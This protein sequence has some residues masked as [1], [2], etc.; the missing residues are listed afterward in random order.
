MLGS[1]G[2]PVSGTIGRVSTKGLPCVRRP[3]RSRSPEGAVGS[4]SNGEPGL[5]SVIGPLELERGEADE[6]VAREDGRGMAGRG[7]Q[8]VHVGRRLDPVPRA[9]LEDERALAA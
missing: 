4:W 6:R 2:S 7:L 8:R 1:M 3:R 5:G 9:V